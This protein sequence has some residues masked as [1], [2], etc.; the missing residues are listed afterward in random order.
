MTLKLLLVLAVV[1]L[2]AWWIGRVRDGRS[3]PRRSRRQA[4]PVPMVSCA[5]CG[6]HLPATESLPDAEGRRYCSAAHRSAGPR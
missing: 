3:A 2:G 6:V 1:L 5:H 4:R